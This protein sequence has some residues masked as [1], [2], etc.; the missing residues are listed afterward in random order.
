MLSPL[1]H[2][3]KR[4]SDQPL[5]PLKVKVT[6]MV[7]TKM[8]S[9]CLFNL[10]LWEMHLQ[11]LQVFYHPFWWCGWGTFGPWW[12]CRPLWVRVLPCFAF[13]LPP[14]FLVVQPTRSP[15]L[16]MSLFMKNLRE[17]TLMEVGVH[18]FVAFLY[19]T[20]EGWCFLACSS[21]WSCAWRSPF[22][23]IWTVGASWYFAYRRWCF[24]SCAFG[25]PWL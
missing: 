1:W 5:M 23:L 6:L 22:R 10:H 12:W 11:S 7:L 15:L 3:I 14:Q 13:L 2:S 19:F 25:N 9:K 20:H 24:I 18:P 16:F 4:P 8:I 21:R 17:W